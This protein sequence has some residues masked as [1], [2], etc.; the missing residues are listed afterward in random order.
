MFEG[1]YDV[2]ISFRGSLKLG[3]ASMGGGSWEW[4]ASKEGGGS[5]CE[6]GL[7]RAVESYYFYLTIWAHLRTC[8]GGWGRGRV[9]VRSWGGWHGMMYCTGYDFPMVV[10]F[11]YNG[12]QRGWGVYGVVHL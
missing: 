11:W 1:G 3:D 12:R 9:Q 5:H 10:V 7:E 6:V 2:R 4:D 8:G